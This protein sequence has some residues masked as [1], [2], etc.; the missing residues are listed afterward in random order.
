MSAASIRTRQTMAALTGTWVGTS[1]M[2]LMPDDPYGESPATATVRPAARGSFATVAY[3]WTTDGV[4][5]D[6][7]LLLGDGADPG[8]AVA[9]WCDSWHQSPHWMTC[10]GTVQDQRITVAGSYLGGDTTAGWRIRIDAS[11]PAVLRIA[12]DNVLREVGYQVVDARY[13]RA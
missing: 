12:M 7:F 8:T 9:V 3:T 5:Q 1:R 13:E 4:E 2:R 11:D 10:E 6:G